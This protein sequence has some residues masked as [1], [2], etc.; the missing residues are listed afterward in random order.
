MTGGDDELFVSSKA[1]TEDVDDEEGM[2]VAKT[3]KPTAASSG[4]G[5]LFGND[6]DELFADPAPK[7]EPQKKCRWMHR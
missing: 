5:G 1:D 4:G 6:D 3:T 2:P 7:K